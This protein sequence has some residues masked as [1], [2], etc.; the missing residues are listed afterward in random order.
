MKVIFAAD[1]DPIIGLGHLQ[2][3]LSLGTALQH[4]G[5]LCAFL[6]VQDET[7]QTRV[8]K[9]GFEVIPLR[10][11]D[12]SSDDHWGEVL[13]VALSQGCENLIVDSYN[14]TDEHLRQM[15]EA[16]LFVAAVDDYAAFPFPCQLVVN[17]SA[18]ASELPYRSLSGDTSFLLGPTYALL[19]EEFWSI[20]SRK[21]RD[22]VQNIL[23][24]LGGADQQ[25][26][27]PD[28]IGHLDHLPIDFNMTIIVGPF[29]KNSSQLKLTA[30]RCAKS[31][32][33]LKDPELLRDHMLEADLAI[34]AGGQTLYE[35]AATGTP[36]VAI[37]TASNQNHN[38]EALASLGTIRFA[39]QTGDPQLIDNVGKMVMELIRQPH[40]R[41]K[42][43]KAGLR[44]VDGRGAL[45][46][47][48]VISDHV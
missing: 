6:T 37:Q 12:P 20:K 25:N 14:V 45:R 9:F 10:D 33:L 42:I 21:I 47:A 43:S 31:A 2:R 48:N 24:T 35:L 5:A 18:K 46:V 19:G 16:G 40:L 29:F 28:L 11:R 39:G 22:T 8:R 34:S 44:L 3:C 1:A 26:V 7:V 41:K 17:G 38:V 32:L 27:T 15:R 23:I 13:Q 30:S 4:V 36:A